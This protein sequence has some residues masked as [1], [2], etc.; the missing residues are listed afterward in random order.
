MSSSL[1]NL[2]PDFRRLRDDGYV[3]ECKGGFLILSDV[4]FLD[5]EQ[6]VRRG[7]LI[8][9]VDTIGDTAREPTCH[10]IWFSGGVPFD[11]RGR[12]LDCVTPVSR[13]SVLGHGLIS[14]CD[15][16]CKPV[17]REFH[18]YHEMMSAYVA[19]L[20]GAA[21]AVDPT[22]TARTRRV[23]ADTD[24]RSV[25]VY[26]DTASARAGIG[27]MNERLAGGSVGIVGLGG[28]GAYILDLVAKTPV[29]RIHLFDDDLF[30]Q[31]NA[32][33]APGAASIAD[34]EARRRKVDHFAEIY[35]RMHSGIVP[36]RMPLGPTSLH[37]LDH[38][39]FVFLCVDTATAR[40]SI[41][42]HLER[43][44]LSFI[45]VGMGLEIGED[46]LM[47]MVRLTT[48]TPALRQAARER[49]P[50]ADDHADDPYATNIQVADLN[51]LNAA[52]AVIRW[53][54]LR[55]FYADSEQEHASVYSVDGNHLI[56]EDRAARP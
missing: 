53:K 29:P 15:L 43:R 45:D 23:I 25:F 2:R 22:V 30:L 10:Q 7:R 41:I 42:P 19:L 55:G 21:I 44:G 47:G 31:H 26:P 54:R 8:A 48:S 39:D 17:D 4:P 28:T 56:N 9:E 24:D 51:A 37:L 14:D 34:L 18:D 36:H 35:A 27:A 5:A 52:L 11:A 33:R 38:V 13:P 16:C 3:L 1:I 6:Q 20:E 46:G 12:Q 49:I 50:M 40:R 32:F